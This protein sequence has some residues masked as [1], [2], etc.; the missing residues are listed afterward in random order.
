MADS[1]FCV[2]MRSGAILR[3]PETKAAQQQQQQQQ[4]A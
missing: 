1:N 3:L 2:L 4:Q